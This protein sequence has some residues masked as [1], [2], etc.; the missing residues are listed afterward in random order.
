MVKVINGMKL[1]NHQIEKQV[2]FQEKWF[3]HEII[4]G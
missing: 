3:K 1:T 4:R 2:K